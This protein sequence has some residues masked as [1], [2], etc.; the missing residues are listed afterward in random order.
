MAQPG[1]TADVQAGLVRLLGEETEKIVKKLEI[2]ARRWDNMYLEKLRQDDFDTTD[3]I[4]RIIKKNWGRASNDSEL[5]MILR[6]SV[7]TFSN[8]HG[9]VAVGVYV[10][11]EHIWSKLTNLDGF[12]AGPFRTTPFALVRQVFLGEEG[13][14]SEFGGQ[15]SDWVSETVA[16][17]CRDQMVKMETDKLKNVQDTMIREANKYRKRGGAF[18]VMVGLLDHLGGAK[19]EPEY[20][21]DEE[22]GHG[23]LQKFK[24]MSDEEQDEYMLT[25]SD[26]DQTDFEPRLM[27]IFWFMKKAGITDQPMKENWGKGVGQQARNVFRKLHSDHNA[28]E[29]DRKMLLVYMGIYSYYTRKYL[30][31]GNTMRMMYET[32]DFLHMR[33][34]VME[35]KI[36]SAGV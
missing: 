4:A 9:T 7:P 14:A 15:E 13:E 32:L 19:E 18:S 27:D 25:H 35:S 6:I 26:Y 23:D 17:F 2:N 29:H 20:A 3:A 1:L 16:A 24:R 21:Y 11:Y 34:I 12:D 10:F 5:R 33:V 8:V 30:P 28:N 31:T 22:W 36:R